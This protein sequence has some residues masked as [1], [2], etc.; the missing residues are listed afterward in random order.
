M[1]A[2]V[3][4]VVF[5]CSATAPRLLRLLLNPWKKLLKN[6][7]NNKTTKYKKLLL[8]K[9]GHE[10]ARL[11]LQKN[12]D[13]PRVCITPLW[14]N[15][16]RATSLQHSIVTKSSTSTQV[17]ILYCHKIA[18]GPRVCI[19]QYSHS[20]GVCWVLVLVS[21]GHQYLYSSS[22]SHSRSRSLTTTSKGQKRLSEKIF[23]LSSLCTLTKRY[24]F[25]SS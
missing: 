21:C 20:N 8:S 10:F 17:A 16:R 9:T 1:S 19:V 24:Q 15:R 12:A 3:L 23:W 4:L 11:N 18:Y 7:K 14:K 22:R 13:R 5:N 25:D 2:S 6:W